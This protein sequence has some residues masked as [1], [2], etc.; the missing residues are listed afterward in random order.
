[1]AT[2]TTTVK[3]WVNDDTK[4]VLTE[5]EINEVKRDRIAYYH[6]DRDELYDMFDMWCDHEQIYCADLFFAGEETRADYLA[7][8]DKYLADC[9]D[10]YIEDEYTLHEIEVDIEIN[11]D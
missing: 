6:S 10:A 2:I 1:M 8:F 7:Q 3:V 5:K 9:A 4:D 11:A